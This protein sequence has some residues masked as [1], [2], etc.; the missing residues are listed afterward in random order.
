MCVD[1]H[2]HSIYSDGTHYPAELVRLAVKHG[3]RSIAL[4]D[5]DTV[6]GVG[7]FLDHGRK[8][9]LPVLSGLEVS[10]THRGRSIHILGYG[11][12]HTSL[13][14][15]RRLDTLQRGRKERNE[16]IIAALRGLGLDV[17]V[18]ELQAISRCGQTGRPHIAALLLHKGMVESVNEAFTRYLRKGAPA[19]AARLSYTAAESIN[20]IHQAGGIAVLAHP[21]Q[22]DPELRFLSLLVAELAE[23][24]LDGI[25][26]YYPAHS[27]SLR[28]RL[29]RMAKK[30]NIAVTGGS[31][32]HGHNR[33][34]TAMAGN[35]GGFC[36]PDSILA[37]LEEKFEAMRPAGDNPGP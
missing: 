28:K 7:E 4:T 27:A 15:L 26:V 5:H 9:S 23:L 37:A 17:R 19:W 3:L 25:E 13:D 22:L 36:P 8:H 18:D 30:Y 21:G 35:G 6:E 11:I 33:A 16:M 1:L 24:G 34:Y 10:A 14:L 20:M 32:Y 31:D 29:I 2:L 12:D